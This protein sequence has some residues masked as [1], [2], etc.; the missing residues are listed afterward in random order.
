MTDLIPPRNR[1]QVKPLLLEVEREITEDDIKSFL[2]APPIV[3]RQAPLQ[4]LRTI[5]HRQAQLIASG[6]SLVEISHMVGTTPHRLSSLCQ[7][8][9]FKELVAFYQD[10]ASEFMHE[11]R[12]R[13]ESK[14]IDVAEMALDELHERL[15]TNPK[16]VP[17][18]ELRKA[19]EMGFD[20]TIAPSKTA[21]NSP[22]VPASITLN[23]GSNTV[24]TKPE[25]KVIEHDSEKVA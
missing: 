1:P 7:D 8:P 23:F 24:L 22:I 17:L 16:A 18:A 5:H 10:Q 19:A 25:P 6:K 15:D 20:R 3:T 21:Q 2:A 11:D 14:L 12:E 13:I 4:R 9:T